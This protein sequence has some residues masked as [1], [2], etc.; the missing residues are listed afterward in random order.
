[1]KTAHPTKSPSN[2]W[3]IGA[4]LGGYLLIAFVF[5]FWGE[6][7]PLP[8]NDTGYVNGPPRES[9]LGLIGLVL[10]GGFVTL[11]GVLQS[12]FSVQVSEKLTRFSLW[13]NSFAIFCFGLADFGTKYTVVLRQSFSPRRQD[14][15]VLAF[16]ELNTII[17]SIWHPD[18]GGRE[19]E[20]AWSA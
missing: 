16:A 11:L 2:T 8:V 4:T 1:V 9:Y 14:G 6:G 20:R 15:V 3:L 18:S 19:P 7:L 17:G 12:V 10:V 5:R 13:L